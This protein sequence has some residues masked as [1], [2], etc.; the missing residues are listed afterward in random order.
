MLISI[1][2]FRA[3]WSPFFIVYL[4]CI[5]VMYFLITVKFRQKFKH[6][7][8][9]TKRE[10]F[11]FITSIILLYIMKGSPLDLL[12]HI[13]FYMHMV[14]M[15]VL[16]L[17][18]PIF[19]IKG[20][21][22]WLWE[23]LFKNKF[24]SFVFTIFT[25]PLLALLLFNV[26]FSFYHI[27]MILDKVKSDLFLHGSYNSLLFLLAIFMWWPILTDIKKYD[28]LSGP[29]KIG[30][31][32]ANGVLITPACALIIFASEPLYTTYS[33]PSAWLNMLALC[34][35]TSTLS[36]LNISGPELFSSMSLL[37]DQQL[38]G[39]LMKVIQEI[40]YGFILAKI[41]YKW[42][43]LEAGEGADKILERK[44]VE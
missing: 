44:I 40:V 3:L 15:A 6:S 42:Y 28:T 23:L 34:V 29:L 7:K 20:I 8:P 24:V 14:Q 32:F 21:P 39:V 26:I 36:S 13:L 9:L 22:V 30:Y 11:S 41:F 19:L 18:I 38:G 5:I 35:P 27:P 33:D 2:G 17:V 16:Y 37:H 25:K 1:F 31:I 43:Q 10:A 4:I 12:S